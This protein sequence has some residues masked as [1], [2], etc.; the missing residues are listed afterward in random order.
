MRSRCLRASTTPRRSAARSS[1]WTDSITRTSVLYYPALLAFTFIFS[2]WPSALYGTVTL[3][4][5]VVAV[6]SMPGFDAQ[7]AA[8]VKAVVL[9]LTA[10]AVTVVIGNLAVGIERARRAEAVADAIA[11]HQE[12]DRLVDEIHD[13]VAQHAYIL[14]A[15]LRAAQATNLSAERREELLRSISSIARELVLDTRS[16]FAS[17]E[18]SM[19][20]SESLGALVD[21]YA[22][23]FS[24]V[25]DIP[26]T[27]RA[28]DVAGVLPPGAVGEAYR[29]VCEGL[30]N[31]FRH[32]HATHVNITLRVEGDRTIIEVAD[33]GVG[34]VIPTE[35]PGSSDG[36]RGLRGMRA[37]AER[38]GAELIVESSPG[39]G[40]TLRLAIP[41]ANAVE[42]AGHA[43]QNGIG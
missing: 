26:V 19:R 17:A 38:I 27:V 16:L 23:E 14:T 43:Q 40:T 8:D 18:P 15:T 2:G 7:E 37:R 20:G 30:S 9:R 6:L 29:I 22:R 33:D 5:Y 36:G 24:A 12:Q 1:R 35:D 39:H 41:G 3:G 34:M 28:A 42:Q 10:M 31:V 4:T 13:G 21:R 25:T 32:A 11:A